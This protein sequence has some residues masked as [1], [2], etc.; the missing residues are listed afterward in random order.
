MTHPNDML[1]RTVFHVGDTY[2]LRMLSASVG[3]GC[4]VACGGADRPTSPGTVGGRGAIGGAAAFGGAKGS[5]ESS[6][7]QPRGGSPASSGAAATGGVPVSDG[8][9]ESPGGSNAGGTDDVAGGSSDPTGGKST[10]GGAASGGKSASSSAPVGGSAG[11]GTTPAVKSRGCGKTP[12]LSGTRTIQ[13]GGQS[14]SYWLR[15]PDTYDNNTPH[16]LIFGFHWNGGS[17]TDVDS[18]GTSGFTWSYYGLREQAGNSTIFVAPTGLDAALAN[19]GGRD[20]TF[21]DDLVKLI[22]ENLCVDTTRLFSV[23]FSYGGGMSYEIACARVGVF[24]AVAVYAGAQLSGCDD[25][26]KPIAYMGI[27]GITDP[28]CSI[29]GG[30]SLRD[31]FVKNNGCIAMSPPEPSQG[32]KTHICASYAGCASGHP[33]RWCAFDGGG[34]T[35][36]AVEG[37]AV[38]SGG[39]DK[40]WT[41]G[42]VWKFIAQF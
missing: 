7:S 40:T 10:S 17:G 33:V 26:T 4:V 31:K 38:D 21:V 20:L 5:G 8:T 23:G 9:V 1:N 25:G 39:G 37:S 18:D 28:T 15:I 12:T 22:E 19:S 27:H 41:K 6:N 35:P 3:V 30:R 14:R 34:H 29:V 16:R 42:E 13:S 32:S 36:A 2:P 11:N 24:R